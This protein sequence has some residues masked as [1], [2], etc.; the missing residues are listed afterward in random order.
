MK[1]RIFAAS[2]AS[3]MA[4]SSVSVVAFADETKADFGEA[5]TKAELKEY[6]K[7]AE[8][9]A[10]DKLDEYGSVQSEQFEAALEAAKVV[11]GKTDASDVEVVAVYQM[12]KAVENSL[13]MYTQAQL[14]ELVESNRSKY[15]S[16][17]TLNEDFGDLIWTD[18]TFTAFETAFD[19]AEGC[20]EEDDQ[21][22]LNDAYTELYN[23]E[24]NLEEKDK[25]TKSQFRTAYN[26][27]IDLVNNFNDY[28]SWRRG[29]ATVGVKTGELKDDNSDK[30]DF[31]DKTVTYGELKDILYGSSAAIPVSMDKTYGK[32]TWIKFTKVSTAAT[33]RDAVEEQYD[34][35]ITNET[36]NTTTNDGI[37][38]AYN[39]CLD[40]V[41]V[42]KGW[43]VDNVKRG[44]Y[45]AFN[46]LVES[47]RDDIIPKI[48]TAETQATLAALKTAATAGGVV[49][50]VANGKVTLDATSASADFE[51]S[52]N[53]DTNALTLDSDDKTY[54]YDAN[55]TI[56]TVQ[57]GGKLDITKYLPI[58]AT[59]VGTDLD[60]ACLDT[61]NKLSVVYGVFEAVAAL[62]KS[63]ADKKD[64]TTV[65]PSTMNDNNAVISTSLK[66]VAYPLVYRAMAYA[67]ADNFKP[68]DEYKKADVSNLIKDANKLIDD[69]GDAAMFEANNA[70][71]D[72]FRKAAT[73]WVAKANAMRPK[74]KE[75]DAV[76]YTDGKYAE[77]D[78]DSGA[79][80]TVVYKALKAAYKDLN[81]QFAQYPYSYGDVA[82]TLTTV[83][84]G[85]DDGVYGSSADAIASAAESIAYDLATIDE[86]KVAENVIFDDDRNFIAYNRLD[87]KGNDAEKALFKKYKALL[88][89]VEDAKKADEPEV[90]VGDFD[91]DGKITANDALAVLKAYAN[92][93]TLTDAQKKAGDYNKDGIVD[94]KDALAILKA[95]AGIKE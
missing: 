56:K 38:Q 94:A 93:D 72:K 88:K 1:K 70:K 63:N 64:Y 34:K 53:K 23:A 73:E 69:T 77:G 60:A 95:Y 7:T 47:Y 75:G 50:T 71:L 46:D 9:F 83:A 3:V 33:V 48:Y 87:S 55:A 21:R 16:K 44:S 89:A 85:L 12:L 91:G 79:T 84:E 29:K 8:K 65:I 54:T 41:K 51:F 13:E 26:A 57:K 68:A 32:G 18:K 59:I 58:N 90:I 24:K 67:L 81:D 20:L 15:D 25:I 78:I 6:I 61:A 74:Y 43:E 82:A 11:A 19:T 45:T 22:V 76:T 86:F 36:S 42:F 31:A 4:L 52:I 10:E 2:M 80:A 62:D 35:F 17:N 49:L 27:Y 28:E 30:L 40:A 37:L 14:K 5:V 39:A 92:Q 66:S